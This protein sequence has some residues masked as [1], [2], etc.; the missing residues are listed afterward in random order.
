M[1]LISSPKIR[2]DRQ[3]GRLRKKLG[4]RVKE[5]MKEKCEKKGGRG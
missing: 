4:G 5:G 3:R 1:G 2:T